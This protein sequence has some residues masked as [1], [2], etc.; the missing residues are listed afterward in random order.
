MAVSVRISGE[1]HLNKPLLCRS[2]HATAGKLRYGADVR[3]GK[4][5]LI[6]ATPLGVV[7]GLYE[8]WRFSPG[9]A[10]LM[11]A[12]LTVVTAGVA[13]I[14]GTIRRENAEERERVRGSG[15]GS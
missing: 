12:L 7:T 11:V 2:F 1:L 13:A 3:I 14:V 5:L 6:V 9:L 8:A 10:F 4:P 15:P